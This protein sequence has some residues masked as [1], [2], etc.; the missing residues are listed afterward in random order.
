ME[1][2][3][4]TS[5]AIVDSPQHLLALAE[6][7]LKGLLPGELMLV[8]ARA[9]GRSGQPSSR[10]F[11]TTLELLKD[12]I[13][14]TKVTR[15]PVFP[16][17]QA[18]HRSVATRLIR[19]G[20]R[21]D[22][23]ALATPSAFI[24]RGAANPSKRQRVYWLDDGSMSSSTA[25]IERDREPQST[26][27]QLNRF[28]AGAPTAI[29]DEI[30]FTSYPDFLRGRTVLQNDFSSLSEFV[31]SRT[32]IVQSSS[33]PTAFVD[34]NHRGIPLDAW[35]EFLQAVMDQFEIDLYVPHRFTPVAL[36]D[37]A[38]RE[39]KAQVLRPN[40]PVELWILSAHRPMNLLLSPGSTWRTVDLLSRQPTW[41]HSVSFLELSDWFAAMA[42]RFP[43][44]EGALEN[45]AKIY[46]RAQSIYLLDD[47]A[48]RVQL[49]KKR[50]NANGRE[51]AC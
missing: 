32:R 21:A 47:S 11:D 28:I 23:L 26:W 41:Q 36:Q 12:A 25:A 16:V 8:A 50:L 20:V 14:P 44:P 22:S 40:A 38:K 46:R 4:L 2:A 34:T 3:T 15:Y 29:A 30:F 48:P 24:Y 39:L 13:R 18:I 37:F 7:R 51:G 49:S 42:P 10:I 43:I 9:V 45:R 31:S 17:G 1:G 35:R 19:L 5:L 33:S 27:Q 6:L